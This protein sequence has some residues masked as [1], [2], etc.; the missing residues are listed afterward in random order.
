MHTKLGSARRQFLHQAALTAGAFAIPPAMKSARADQKAASAA[1]GR[2]AGPPYLI[3]LPL[4]PTE[5]PSP[6]KVLTDR[7]Y[8]ESLPI[9]GIVIHNNTVV[10]AGEKVP[11]CVWSNRDSLKPAHVFDE[12]APLKGKFSKLNRSW[13]FAT[14]TMKAGDWFADWSTCVGNFAVMA[15]ACRDLGMEGLF[16]DNTDNK[17]HAVPLWQFPGP[18]PNPAKS[19]NDYRRQVRLRGKQ[20]MEACVREYP[21][22]K[23]A[24]LIGPSSAEKGDPFIEA[25]PDYSLI[26]AFYSGL[27]AGAG[28]TGMVIDTNVFYK[29]AVVAGK[30]EIVS[31]KDQKMFAGSYQF[32]KYEIPTSRHDSPSLSPE[33]RAL[34]TRRLRVGYGM[35]YGCTQEGMTHALTQSDYLSWYYNGANYLDPATLNEKWFPKEKFPSLGAARATARS[36]NNRAAGVHFA[37]AT[38]EL[39]VQ[40]TAGDASFRYTFDIDNRTGEKATINYPQKPAWVKAVANSATISGKPPSAART[41]ALVAVVSAGGK[42]DTIKVI[43]DTRAG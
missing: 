20:I 17:Y 38:G 2:S 36:A 40:A 30:D 41:D 37:T 31:S 39:A 26:T 12:V 5:D 29:R 32:R 8:I 7:A 34:W 14:S 35:S 19:L 4:G 6:A 16:L 24:L 10:A 27:L 11:S 1:P 42:S 3:F 28:E 25:R 22:F 33:D 43:L 18:K 23:L 9:D 21:T 15:R 13:L